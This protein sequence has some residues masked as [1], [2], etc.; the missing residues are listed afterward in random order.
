MS[1]AARYLAFILFLAGTVRRGSGGTRAGLAW[2]PGYYD[3][4]LGLGELWSDRPAHAE[5]LG[6]EGMQRRRT[7]PRNAGDFR[8]GYDRN[9]EKLIS[10]PEWAVAGE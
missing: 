3:A 9:M 4:M 2:S 8:F 1:I 5:Q 7:G 6:R 10:G